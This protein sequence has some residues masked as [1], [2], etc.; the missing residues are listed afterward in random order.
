MVKVSQAQRKCFFCSQALD[1]AVCASIAA[2]NQ[3]KNIAA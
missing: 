3:K 2:A 1:H